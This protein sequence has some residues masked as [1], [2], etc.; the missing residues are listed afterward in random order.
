ME[1]TDGLERRSDVEIADDG[2]AER[3]GIGP[4]ERQIHLLY[5]KARRLEPEPPQQT[6][7]DREDD[8]RERRTPH[9][10]VILP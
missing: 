1:V 9:L 7:H 6:A 5:P 10:H 3:P 4:R 2:D 8:R